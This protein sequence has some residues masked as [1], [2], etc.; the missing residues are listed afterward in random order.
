MNIGLKYR[1][2]THKYVDAFYMASPFPRDWIH[3]LNANHIGIED[4]DGYLMPK[5]IQ[6]VT[7]SG[8]FIVLKDKLR[9]N[10]TV[11]I[12]HPFYKFGSHVFL[13]FNAVLDPPVTLGESNA[14]SLYPVQCFHPEKGIVGWESDEV[15]DWNT[16]AFE[17]KKDE[18][19]WDL[20]THSP[21]N[22]PKITS[23]SLVVP[24]NEEDVIKGL[25]EEVEKKDL[26]DIL[27]DDEE[28]K[29]PIRKV[30]DKIG[31]PLLKGGILLV[32]ALL[33]IV[34]GVG[35]L[36]AGLVHIFGPPKIG[37]S[38]TS[39]GT[40]SKGPTPGVLK[41]FQEW[42]KNNLEKL[43]R[44]QQKELNKL[45]KMFD[46][47]L[48]EALKYAIPLGGDELGRGNDMPSYKLT[49]RNPNFNL[50]GAGSR[51][52]SYGWD[53]GNH[54]FELRQKYILGAKAEV[55]H[56][57]Y[58]KAAYIYAHLLKDYSSAANVLEQGGYYEEAAVLYLEKMKNKNGAALCYEKGMLYDKAIELYKTLDNNEKVGDL[59]SL[60][61]N[62]KLSKE[63]YQITSSAYVD[64]R[65]YYNAARVEKEKLEN[66]DQSK[67]LLLQ[68]WKS[69]SKSNVCLSKY[70]EESYE[71]NRK[72]M[73]QVIHSIY[74]N[75][76]ETHLES[77]FLDVLSNSPLE[78][79]EAEDAG[80]EI[81]YSIVSKKLLKGDKTAAH[82]LQAF[83]SDRILN[84]DVNRFLSHIPRK[85][86]NTNLKI[87]LDP[88]ITWLDGISHRDSMI[89][90]G[91]STSHWFLGR[92]NKYGNKAYFA[93]ENKYEKDVLLLLENNP[94]YTDE[95]LCFFSDGKKRT[96]ENIEMTKSKYFDRTLTVTYYPEFHDFS[97]CCTLNAKNYYK[98]DVSTGIV[99]FDINRNL[100]GHV[101]LEE[102]T[103]TFRGGLKLVSEK[104]YLITYADNDF[105][106]IDETTAKVYPLNLGT[107]IK[108]FK[109]LNI[110]NIL[111][112]T[113]SG[114]CI[115]SYEGT[116]G[117]VC[118]SAF[119][120]TDFYGKDSFFLGSDKVLV[121]SHKLIKIYDVGGKTPS[122]LKTIDQNSI[123]K[124]LP[125]S[126]NAYAVLSDTKDLEI[127]TV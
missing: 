118:K 104:G 91:H 126:R 63:F 19:D 50:E 117:F 43:E 21:F 37:G 74:K 110:S 69:T 114:L 80:Q 45:L 1:H 58:R 111:I 84:S 56:K 102:G 16:I 39:H 13:P 47:N 75:H 86:Y 57:N 23:L 66:P 107:T 99:K 26:A 90:V 95:I 8:I 61:H 121:Y 88:A 123:L 100:E 122:L 112:I 127:H 103:K 42:L 28:K 105:F 53:L 15:F 2:N 12:K 33:G 25:E 119:F 4:I 27:L 62:T 72:D 108:D 68:G 64:K 3:V 5:S 92:V 59:Y 54:Y 10:R 55:E 32:G 40:S 46:D 51:I 101:I 67:R 18:I 106:V 7:L 34:G 96:L 41:S 22:I 98:S 14:L 120:S 65:D 70:L 71:S 81:A 35:Y 76:T 82:K 36:L 94:L 38:P 115:Y 93:L 89:F 31:K 124:C 87:K 116:K 83:V 11:D 52:S 78:K 44:E 17:L 73:P 49:K 48:S 20:A 29:A 125:I 85:I 77:Q 6:D 113:Y 79:Y 24:E 60:T 30:L 9:L 97:S 109:V